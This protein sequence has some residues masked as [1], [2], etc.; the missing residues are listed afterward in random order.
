MY[1]IGINVSLSSQVLPCMPSGIA[2]MAWLSL[3]LPLGSSCLPMRYKAHAEKKIRGWR[4]ADISSRQSSLIMAFALDGHGGCSIDIVMASSKHSDRHCTN[5]G[6]RGS[7]LNCPTST[8]PL[9]SGHDG[10]QWQLSKI[11]IIGVEP[12][13][14]AASLFFQQSI[15]GSQV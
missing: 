6:L 3:P 8:T 7:G 12:E 15:L 2:G 9:L 10:F 1:W 11:V 13:K 14:L 4:C 5:T